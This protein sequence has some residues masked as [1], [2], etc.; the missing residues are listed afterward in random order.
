MYS[1]RLNAITFLKLIDSSLCILIISLYRVGDD[2]VAKPSTFLPLS[3]FNLTRSH[4][5]LA[6]KFDAISEL[7]KVTVWSFSNL[8]PSFIQEIDISD[9]LPIVDNMELQS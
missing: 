9:F 2:P 1:S 5:S 6:I 7:S 3:C 4:I 8:V